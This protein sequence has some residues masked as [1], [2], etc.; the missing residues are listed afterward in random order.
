MFVTK[1]PLFAEYF[2]MEKKFY[3]EK[4]FCRKKHFLQRKILRKCKNYISHLRN[5]FLYREC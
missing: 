4:F 2:Y 5:I 3:I 1:Y